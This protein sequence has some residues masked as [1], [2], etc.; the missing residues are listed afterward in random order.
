MESYDKVDPEEIIARLDKL[1]AHIKM[2]NLR[3]KNEA[4]RKVLPEDI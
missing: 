3:R 1:I 4:E 2:L